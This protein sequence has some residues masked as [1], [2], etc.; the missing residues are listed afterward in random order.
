MSISRR[1]ALAAAALAVPATAHTADAASRFPFRVTRNCPWTLV[2]LKGY[3]PH[4][5]FVLDTG[6]SSFAIL[7]SKASELNLPLLDR[8]QA[9]NLGLQLDLTLYRAQL[10]VGGALQE[11]D[12]YMVGLPGVLPQ[13]MQGLIPPTRFGVMGFDFDA[14]EVTI[15][16]RTIQALDGYHALDLDP[17]ETDSVSMDNMGARSRSELF[18]WTRDHRPVVD[19]ELDGVKLKLLID[20]GASLG[21]YLHAHYVK[22]V[23]LWDR[24]ASAPSQTLHVVGGSLQA[25]LIRAER[26]KLGN[27]VF[28]KP[29][30]ALGDPAIG[31]KGVGKT[32]D[33]VIGMEFL[34]RLNFVHDPQRRRFWIKPNKAIADGYR[35][36]RAGAYVEF[37]DG[38][39]RVTSLWPGSPADRAGLR[40]NDKITGWRGRDGIEGLAWAMMGAPGSTVE[41]QVEREGK[42]QMVA[43]TLEEQI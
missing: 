15:S 39:G 1:D 32:I 30:V 7:K 8:G 42:L 17:G 11:N 31:E 38:A 16:R 33:G 5:P 22:K 35:Y 10:V 24:N 19:V 13:K 12:A 41:I 18:E 29:V 3:E 2:Q 23:G 14:Q 43:V 9:R 27:V 37:V 25:H 6:A 4:L 28:S 34:R 26:L 36:D 40:L 21:I 20:T